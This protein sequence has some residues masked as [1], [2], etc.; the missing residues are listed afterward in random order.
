MDKKQTG[1][2]G[3]AVC[4]RYY[5]KHGFTVCARNFHSRFGEID[6]IAENADQL[7][8]IE[9]KTREEGQRTLP[10]EAVDRAKMR[11][12]ARTAQAFLMQ[13]GETEKQMQFDVFEV[14]TRGGRPALCRR[15][16]NAFDESC[17]DE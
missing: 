11:R 3:E 6:V 8:F 9:V 5:E 2:C 14:L 13:Y 4:A 7:I 10:C 16:E 17:L 12:L 15:I 1:N